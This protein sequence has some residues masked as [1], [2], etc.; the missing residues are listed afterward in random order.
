[1]RDS[2][3]VLRYRN[4]IQATPMAFTLFEKLSNQIRAA[5]KTKYS[6]WTIV[7]IIRWES[8]LAQSEE[9]KI[10]ND[11]IGL[12]ARDLIKKDPSFDGFFNLKKTK[13]Y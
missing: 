6:A 1:M 5:G 9:Y 13:R 3:L 11:Y 10:S 4:W 12:L 7:N 2:Q 8:D